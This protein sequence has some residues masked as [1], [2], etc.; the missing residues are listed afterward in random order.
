MADTNAWSQLWNSPRQNPRGNDFEDFILQ[1]NVKVLNIGNE[2]TYYKQDDERNIR[3]I[4]DVS[5]CSPGLESLVSNWQV[6]DAVPSSD[7]ASIEFCFHIDN[8]GIFEQFK[9]VYDF[10]KCQWK[11]FKAKL[12]E[13]S[14][15][16]LS[17]TDTDKS[18]NY[19]ILV[20]ETCHWHTRKQTPTNM[21]ITEVIFY[22]KNAFYHNVKIAA[23]FNILLTLSS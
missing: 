13:L 11:K 5:F 22:I 10:A 17:Q 4:I 23:S 7:H 2:W 18:W 8:P 12:E 14:Q 21:H 15:K 6:R 1:H 9:E 20:K 19:E 3:S 16:W